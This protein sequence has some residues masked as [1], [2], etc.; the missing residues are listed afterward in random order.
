M[1]EQTPKSM[2]NCALKRGAFMFF[3]TLVVV[4][5]GDRLVWHREGA[6]PEERNRERMECMAEAR[7]YSFTEGTKGTQ[8]IITPEGEL[9]LEID[10]EAERRESEIFEACMRARGYTRI[11]K[12]AP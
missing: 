2:N 1:S 8:R 3:A 12:E 11:E 5:C 6:T 9:I 4:S 10:P 7:A